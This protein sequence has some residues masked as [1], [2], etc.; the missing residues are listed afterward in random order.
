MTTVRFHCMTV[1]GVFTSQEIHIN[2][3]IHV[4]ESII[5]HN[6]TVII[7]PTETLI[8]TLSS[9]KTMKRKGGSSVN[10]THLHFANWN[11]FGGCAIAICLG[12][13]CGTTLVIRGLKLYS[14]NRLINRSWKRFKTTSVFQPTSPSEIAT[15]VWLMYSY[16]MTLCRNAST[17][18]KIHVAP[19][20]T[21]N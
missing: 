18:A 2:H 7:S 11:G 15:E 20:K 13:S 10:K 12:E 4:P 17:S 5:S 9:C 3:Q 1:R 8:D 6:A 16:T 14:H 21:T 19:L